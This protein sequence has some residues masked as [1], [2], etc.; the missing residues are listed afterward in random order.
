MTDQDKLSEERPTVLEVLGECL[1]EL[2]TIAERLADPVS[3]IEAVEI[4]PGDT[5]VV[6]LPRNTPIDRVANAIAPLQKR[7]PDNG[8]LVMAGDEK[9][10]VIRSE[11]VVAIR[12]AVDFGRVLKGSDNGNGNNLKGSDNGNGN[13]LS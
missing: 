10:A 9:L 5:L 8:V 13:N 1:A 4:G 6:T 12:P 3:R 2:R 11:R 7:F